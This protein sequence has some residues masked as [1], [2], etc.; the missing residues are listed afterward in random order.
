MKIFEGII[1]SVPDSYT[2]VVEIT[3]RV[4]HKIYGKL[5]K[6]SSKFKI[7]ITGTEVK[8]GDKVSFVETRPLSKGKNFKLAPSKERKGK[9]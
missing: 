9:K 3:R 6:K 2:G 5:I 8:V 4:P 7:D 1:V